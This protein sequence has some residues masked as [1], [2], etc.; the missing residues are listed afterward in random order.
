MTN[1]SQATPVPESEQW[2]DVAQSLARHMLASMDPGRTDRLFPA[3]PVVFQTNALNVA[4]GACGTSLFLYDVLGELP[5]QVRTWLL[6]R[7]VDITTHA[8]GL[9]SG[10]AGIAWSFAEL[11]L[12]ERGLELFDLVPRSPLAFTSPDMFEG[13]AGWG[14]SAL[15]LHLRTGD[16]KLL[17]LAVRAGEH[18]LKTARHEEAGACWRHGDEAVIRL[19]FAY[20]GSGIALFLLYLWHVT[21]DARF[22]DVAKRA[23]DFE[24][25]HGQVRG[26][27]LVWGASTGSLGHR[28]YWQR[29]GAGVTAALIRFF[30]LLGEEQY[31][32]LA[33]RAA[34]GCSAFFSTAPHLF[35]GLTSM[36]ES[37]LD[38]FQVTGE[39][40]YL[41]LARQKASQTLLY[42]IERPEGVVFPGR[43]LMR[44]S[45]DYGVGGAGIGLFLVRLA[46]RRPRRFHDLFP[47]PSK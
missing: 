29:G 10:I 43:Y 13:V 21:R 44:I 5:E 6:A 32:D 15:A 38:M 3:D 14:L 17:A 20:G 45:H 12:L 18:L 2:T 37:L 42:R 39:S 46:G 8:P 41:E 24:V 9:Y 31:L 34:R 28:P 1:A 11:G 30:Q 33:R 7:P 36:G 25:A 22:L 40:Q 23:M 35:E 47:L 4:Y 16:A 19:G 26:D 27:A